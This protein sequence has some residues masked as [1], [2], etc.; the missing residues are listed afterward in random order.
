MPRATRYP[1][2]ATQNRVEDRIHN[3]R[4]I[5]TLAPAASA[6]AA[7]A[8]VD[9][10]RAE[11]PDATHHCFAFVAGPPGSSSD[12]GSGDDGEPG[13]TAGRPMLNVLLNSGVGDVAVVVT[14]YFG[15]VKL[16]KGGLVRAYSGAVQ[17]ALREA[18]TVMRVERIAVRVRFA[19]PHT[20][21]VRRAL[22]REDAAI[23]GE[24]FGDEVEL[25]VQLPEDRL[26]AIRQLLLD[27]TAGGARL[28]RAQ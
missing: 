8:L 18:A 5:A 16:G 2:P 23:T 22:A 3:S 15:G 19:Y 25:D 14:R 10:V 13:G 12:I 7:R 26:D 24:R 20:D 28:E 21:S 1:V 6:D 17:H 11:F 27:L 9:A 4:F